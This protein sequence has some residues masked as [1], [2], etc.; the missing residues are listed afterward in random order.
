MEEGM[1]DSPV[2]IPT[3]GKCIDNALEE[4]EYRIKSLEKFVDDSACQKIQKLEAHVEKLREH[5]IKDRQRY[6]RRIVE[7]ERKVRELED[8]DLEL[9][10]TVKLNKLRIEEVQ[11]KLDA[12]GII[13][14]QGT[15]T[16]HWP[17]YPPYY[18]VKGGA[19]GLEFK[20]TCS[21]C[22]EIED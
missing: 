16:N 14:H 4:L 5:A 3:V 7:L 20:Y 13:N 6:T 2:C 1:K 18:T 11:E 22:N 19:Q 9:D 21:K 12:H 8:K 17:F 10:T 15:S